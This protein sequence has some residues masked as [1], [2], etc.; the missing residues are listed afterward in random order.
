LISPWK[1]GITI[2]SSVAPDQ[3]IAFDARLLE[4]E[5]AFSEESGYRAGGQPAEVGELKIAGALIHR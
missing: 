1:L 3:S 2:Y 5:T 4:S